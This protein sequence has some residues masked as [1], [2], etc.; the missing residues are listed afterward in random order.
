MN[1]TK[2][3]YKAFLEGA[4]TTEIKK[5]LKKGADINYEYDDESMLEC[6]IDSGDYEMA[7]F[8][9]EN[10]ADNNNI[11][12]MKVAI[13]HNNIEMVKLLLDYEHPVDQYNMDDLI[14]LFQFESYK[15][16]HPEIFELIINSGTHINDPNNQQRLLMFTTI[17]GCPMYLNYLLDIGCKFNNV[18][19]PITDC[20][21]YN[22]YDILEIILEKVKINS[23]EKK[24][25]R[26]FTHL[27]TESKLLSYY[28]INNMMNNSIIDSPDDA[29]SELDSDND[30][31]LHD[32][33]IDEWKQEAISEYKIMQLLLDHRII[34]NELIEKKARK[35]LCK[36]DL[37]Y[38]GL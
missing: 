22:D 11:Q 33:F 14:D 20:I 3:M 4:D 2:K 31:I 15:Y 19:E 12:L 30:E 16:E 37:K 9:L 5:Y 29:A 34:S 13:N 7:K 38:I 35:I 1:I 24:E 28:V 32:L 23:A 25:I 8:L 18:V 36:A 17:V 27:W 21:D 26:S 6:S 10:G